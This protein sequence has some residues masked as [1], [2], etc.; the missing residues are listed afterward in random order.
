VRATLNALAACCLCLAAPATAA[1]EWHF[2]PFVGVT[3]RGNTTIIDPEQATG[4]SHPAFGGAVSLL[5]NGILGAE[6]LFQISPYFFQGSENRVT[7]EGLPIR[8]DLIASS[9]VIA[10][11]GNVVVAAPRRYTEYFLRPFVSGGFGVLRVSK[12]EVQP[13]GG[14]E[15][16]PLRANFAAFNIGGGAVGFFSQTTG[17]RFDFRYFSTLHGTDRGAGVTALGD[18][19]RLRY[20]TAS[21]GVVIRR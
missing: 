4:E 2:A 12:T 16:F 8:D 10:A 9:R 11:M 20:L 7:A 3:F 6:G 13:P 19:V 14:F 17:V 18:P 1:A 15:I 21:V 5:G